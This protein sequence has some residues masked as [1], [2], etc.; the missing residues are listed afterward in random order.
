MP[1]ISWP[2]ILD[3][4]PYSV[5]LDH[6]IFSGKRI[7][8]VDGITVH[9]ANKLI[10]VGKSEHPFQ[11]SSHDCKITIYTIGRGVTYDLSIDGKAQDTQVFTLM[12]I[13]RTM[14]AWGWLLELVNVF[15]VAVGLTTISGGSLSELIIHNVLL[16]ILFLVFFFA[17]WIISSHKSRAL[18][19][20]LVLCL[21]LTIVYSFIVLSSTCL[22]SNAG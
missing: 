15:M 3:D 1:I 11:I 12:Q 9:K 17:I 21:S 4:K 22:C 6:G 20:R 10:D 7:I 14:P 13:L 8:Q 2:I 5:E 19:T 16:A 18:R